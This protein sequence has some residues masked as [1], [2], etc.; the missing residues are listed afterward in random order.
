MW[1]SGH[2]TNRLDVCTPANT[3]M[4]VLWGYGTDQRPGDPYGAKTTDAVPLVTYYRSKNV[5][6]HERRLLQLELKLDI[7]VF[8]ISGTKGVSYRVFRDKMFLGLVIEGLR[9]AGSSYCLW[10][11]ITGHGLHNVACD[12]AA[13]VKSLANAYKVSPCTSETIPDST[14]WGPSTE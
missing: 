7:A 9:V 8:R 14:S 2:S 1:G 11:V 6:D 10:T 5:N 13:A 12:P 4:S 3:D